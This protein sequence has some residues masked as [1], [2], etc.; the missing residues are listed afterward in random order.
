MTFLVEMDHVKS[1][2]TPSAGAGRAFIEQII[3]PTLARGAQLVTAGKIVAGGPVVGRIAL[4]FVVEADSTAE[5]DALV[6]AL[7]LW[8]VAETRIVPLTGFA[9]RRA[10]V[11]A[12]LASLPSAANP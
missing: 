4:R 7:P 2:V 9:D 11:E 5:V 3:F 6:S 1:G 12:L 10:R 8:T